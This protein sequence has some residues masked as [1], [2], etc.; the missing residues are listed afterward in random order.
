[1]LPQLAYAEPTQGERAALKAYRQIQNLQQVSTTGVKVPRG[2][3][4]IASDE[5]RNAGGAK[6]ALKALDAEIARAGRV[7]RGAALIFSEDR[8]NLLRLAESE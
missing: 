8:A 5:F 4:L 3:A 7:P 2:A 1:M 6:A